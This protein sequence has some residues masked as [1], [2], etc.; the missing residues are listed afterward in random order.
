MLRAM[1][2]QGRFVG[3]EVL[4]KLDE[5]CIACAKG[6]FRTQSFPRT[7][8]GVRAPVPPYHTL[9]ADGVSGFKVL[10]INKCVGAFVFYARGLGRRFVQLYH[11]FF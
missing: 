3:V 4:A 2:Q 11:F 6:K 10:T 1:Q 7:L 9:D 8:K 5:D